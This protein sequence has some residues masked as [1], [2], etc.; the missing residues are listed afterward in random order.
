MS[1]ASH[2]QHL[3]VCHCP[4]YK[5]TTAQQA[6]SGFVIVCCQLKLLSYTPLWEMGI[7]M[8]MCICISEY[9]VVFVGVYVC[10]SLRVNICGHRDSFIFSFLSFG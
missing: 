5:K 2:I 7:C 9:T 10:A 3:A 1:G 6:H 4:L 8:S